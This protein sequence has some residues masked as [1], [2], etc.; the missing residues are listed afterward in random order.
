MLAVKTPEEA[1]QIIQHQFT[2]P[3]PGEAVPLQE[4]MGR[5][6]SE[7]IV[8]D[9][10]IPAFHRSTVDGWAVIAAETFGCSNSIPALFS[11]RGTV[12]MGE[13]PQNAVLPGTCM[14]IPTGGQLPE[15]ADAVAM[16]EYAEDYG[17]GTIGIC[18]P[19]APKTNIIFQGDDVFPGKSVFHA[20]RRL[21]PQDI[22][23]LAAMGITAVPVRKRPRVAI[24]ST[25]DEL[26]EPDQAPG[27]GQIRDVNTAML[28]AFVDQLGGVPLCQGFLKDDEKCLLAT[29]KN[30]IDACDMVMLS[31]GSS[32]GKKDAAHRVIETMGR[33][34]FHGIAMKPG[35]PTMLGIIA[36][37][38]ILALPGHPAAAA[39]TADLFGRA[40][41]ERLTSSAA[42][43]VYTPA[44][45]DE[46]VGANH[47][48]AE[49][50]A[51]KLYCVGAVRYA[52]PIRSKSG[53]ITA[54]AGSDGWFCIPRDVEGL[55]AG[56]TIQVI[57]YSIP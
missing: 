23:A 18:K 31:G 1:F 32:V 36:G 8:A 20:G 11:K 29:L 13:P 34:L 43:R 10:Y 47:G 16:L 24:I 53:L 25:G 33:L 48:R 27:P 5:I 12:V 2:P 38:P 26:V 14:E 51:V 55:Q 49:Y 15:G 45:L 39:F 57:P 21:T 19:I 50:M 7:D 56:S 44:I 22:G 30:V 46:N 37:K 42:Q 28:A 35:K 17:D 6:L 9:E 41:I 54:L 40:I 3:L 52:H 4:A